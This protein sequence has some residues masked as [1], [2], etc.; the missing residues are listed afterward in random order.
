M[1]PRPCRKRRE[2]VTL[3]RK[4]QLIFVERILTIREDFPVRRVTAKVSLR[5]ECNFKPNKHNITVT[6][7]FVGK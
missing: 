6:A 2:A 7:Q 5:P 4:F 3:D 1:S